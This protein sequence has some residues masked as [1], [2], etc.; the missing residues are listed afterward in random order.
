M[1]HWYLFGKIASFFSWTSQQGWAGMF[2]S[3]VLRSPWLNQPVFIAIVSLMWELYT[4]LILCGVLGTVVAFAPKTLAL[5]GPLRTNGIR[6][7]ALLHLFA[8][9]VHVVGAPFAR[10]SVPFR[11]VT[12]LLAVFLI[13]W[14]SRNYAAYKHRL[15][16]GALSG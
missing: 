14:V 11:P 16:S 15:A 6:F 12:F 4:P 1:L 2:E 7:L 13:V 10:Y 8:I 5:F 9:G 3:P